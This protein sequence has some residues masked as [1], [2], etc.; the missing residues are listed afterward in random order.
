KYD[1]FME[2]QGTFVSF[3]LFLIPGFPKDSLCY[4]MGLSHMKTSTF[5]VIATVGRLFGTLGLSVGGNFA[6]G[7][8]GLL[9]PLALGAVGLVLLLA[10]LFRDRWLRLKK[11][12]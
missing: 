5:V 4:I 10:Y 8:Q 2:H 12:G 6:R 7:G 9:L 11:K 1:H 3:I